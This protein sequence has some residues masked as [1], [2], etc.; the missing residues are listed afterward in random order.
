TE[1][2][3]PLSPAPC[4]YNS[5]TMLLY[6]IAPEGFFAVAAAP[7]APL[8]VL[9]SDPFETRPGGWELGREVDPGAV[10]L[11]APVLPGKIVGIGR[12]YHEHAKELGNP[13]PPEPL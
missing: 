6:R 2:G 5:L 8:S 3:R 9:Y 13:M 11:L 4:R 7:G 12:N 10:Q 1:G